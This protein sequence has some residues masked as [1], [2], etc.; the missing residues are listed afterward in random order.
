LLRVDQWHRRWDS[1]LTTSLGFGVD[2]GD[3]AAGDGF[4]IERREH[5]LQLYPETLLPRSL[6]SD[7]ISSI[8]IHSRRTQRAGMVG[9]NEVFRTTGFR[10]AET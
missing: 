9:G 3:G 7:V 6:G 1:G 2:L 10:A 8:K 4:L 5:L